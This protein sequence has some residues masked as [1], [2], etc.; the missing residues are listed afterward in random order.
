MAKE[1]GIGLPAQQ[2]GQLGKGKVDG[3]VLHPVGIEQGLDFG[4]KSG[5]AGAFF[6]EE[7]GAAARGKFGGLFKQAAH[8]PELFI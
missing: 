2:V 1:I 7:I 4:E 6:C 5:V 8:T 3:G